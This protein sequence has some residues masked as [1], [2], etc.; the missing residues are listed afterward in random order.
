[1][2]PDFADFHVFLNHDK[3]N[4]ADLFG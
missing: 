2:L 4:L 3:T 1:V